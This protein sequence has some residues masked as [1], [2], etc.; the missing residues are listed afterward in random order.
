MTTTLFPCSEEIA[1]RLHPI[2]P[3]PTMM[4]YIQ[5]KGNSIYPITPSPDRDMVDDRE[6]GVDT[7]FIS[8]FHQEG[9][10]RHHVGIRILCRGFL[11]E[12]NLTP[13][14]LFY[15]GMIRQKE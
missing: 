15:R 12:K 10:L 1:M 11:F 9:S 14:L 7:D 2:P 4:M 13:W 6:E 8:R 3:R 5:N